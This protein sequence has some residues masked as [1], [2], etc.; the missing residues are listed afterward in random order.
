MYKLYNVNINLNVK[1]KINETTVTVNTANI[2][3]IKMLFTK[4]ICNLIITQIKIKKRDQNQI[5]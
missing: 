4:I 3:T 1:F 2:S 5:I